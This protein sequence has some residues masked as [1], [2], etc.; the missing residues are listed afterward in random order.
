MTIAN[1]SSSS[2]TTIEMRPIM[3]LWSLEVNSG[4]AS[5]NE[6]VQFGSDINGINSK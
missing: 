5:V 2:E 4:F 6:P 1:L 3:W